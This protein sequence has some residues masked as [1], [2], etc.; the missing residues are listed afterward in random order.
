[1]SLALS[2]PVTSYSA[3][4]TNAAASDARVGARTSQACCGV[5]MKFDQID[6][7]MLRKD[8]AIAHVSWEL[9]GAA[10]VRGDGDCWM[11]LVQGERIAENSPSELPPSCRPTSGTPAP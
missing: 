6:V 1:M 7:R 9:L 11:A 3:P 8:V 4:V 2:P 5:G 10:L